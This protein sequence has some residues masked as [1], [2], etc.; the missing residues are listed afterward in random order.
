[1]FGASHIFKLDSADITE[2]DIDL[3]LERGEKRTQEMN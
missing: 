1:M 2:N 3:L